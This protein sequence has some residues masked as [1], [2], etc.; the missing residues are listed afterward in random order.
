MNRNVK[1][2]TRAAVAVGTLALV[3]GAGVGTANAAGN[4]G[5]GPKGAALSALV[6]AGTITEAQKEEFR[7]EMHEAKEA[8]EASGVKVDCAVI[9]ASVLSGLVSEGTLTQAQADAIKAARPARPEASAR[10]AAAT[11][12]GGG[13]LAALV[14]NGTITQAQADAIKA[15]HPE[16]SASSGRGTQTAPQPAS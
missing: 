7:Y 15:A 8:A 16:R 4:G 11:G 2:G 6:T 10:G 3:I 5:G 13:P 12:T 14:A 1:W 9:E